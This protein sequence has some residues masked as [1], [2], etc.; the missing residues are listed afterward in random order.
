MV[1]DLR[2]HLANRSIQRP[3]SIIVGIWVR[4]SAGCLQILLFHLILLELSVLVYLIAR[5][6]PRFGRVQGRNPA[7]VRAPVGQH[8]GWLGRHCVRI[9]LVD[10]GWGVHRSYGR[11]GAAEGSCWSRNGADPSFFFVAL[12]RDNVLR[13]FTSVH[14]VP[15][16]APWVFWIFGLISVSID[17]WV[18]V[19][20][21]GRTLLMLLLDRVR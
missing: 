13:E 15:I 3:R 12:C 10:D 16:W 1:V 5:C 4:G 7:K 21:D 8:W 11:V 18:R 20:D 17:A 19:E 9:L 2:P 6:L 14:R